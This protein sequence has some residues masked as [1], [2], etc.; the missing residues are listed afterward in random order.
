MNFSRKILAKKGF[1]KDHGC[2][3]VKK[4]T[5]HLVW[6]MIVDHGTQ[7]INKISYGSFMERMTPS[8]QNTR[9]ITELEQI[10]EDVNTTKEKFLAQL[11]G[12]FVNGIHEDKNGFNSNHRFL[13]EEALGSPKITVPE[14]IA[15]ELNPEY[16]SEIRSKIRT[17]KNAKN[18]RKDDKKSNEKKDFIKRPRQEPIWIVKNPDGSV[19]ISNSEPKYDA[20]LERFYSEGGTMPSGDA[21]YYLP[22]RGYI[23]DLTFERSPKKV[24][25]FIF[26]E[27]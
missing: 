17:Q 13:L 24:G 9:I 22:Y 27:Q 21:I 14:D 18:E 20:K 3:Y 12:A 7:K 2:V 15:K 8:T 11:R 6:I 4:D 10:D 23:K 19:F 25:L 5:E 1:K 16:I 26:K